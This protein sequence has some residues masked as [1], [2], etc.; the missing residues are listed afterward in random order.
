MSSGMRN[1]LTQQLRS[2]AILLRMDR[3]T[4]VLE[5]LREE[6]KRLKA[7]LDG[8]ERAIAAL[9]VAEDAHATAPAAPSPPPPAAPP[10]PLAAPGPYAGMTFYEA[11]EKYL[12]TQDGPRSANQIAD[13]LLQDG[14]PVRGQNFRASVRTML[15]R[16]RQ[17]ETFERT[18][19][20]RW[21]LTGKR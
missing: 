13:A 10:P 15:A 20:F 9:E 8:V 21:R 12:K 4:E 19:D 18:S 1:S 3:V 7:E 14:F 6:R 17:F 2:C 5:R 11:A 16:A